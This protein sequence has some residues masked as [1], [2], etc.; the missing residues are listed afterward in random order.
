MRIR[1]ARLPDLLNHWSVRRLK[2]AGADCV[3]VLLYYTPFEKSEINDQKHA[4]IERNGDE[5]R[6]QDIAFFL[7]FV[8]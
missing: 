4:F 8:G 6:A 5:C 3:K 2:E 7:E 1:P